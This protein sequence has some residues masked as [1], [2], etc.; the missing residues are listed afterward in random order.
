MYYN[1]AEKPVNFTCCKKCIHFSKRED[2]DPCWDCLNTRTN[3]NSY[4]P[5][6]YKENKKAMG[7]K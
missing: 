1:E 3:E 7:N 4:K 6:Y 2:E 5:V